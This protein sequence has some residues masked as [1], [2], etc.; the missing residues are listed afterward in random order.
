MRSNGENR[1]PEIITVCGIGGIACDSDYIGVLANLKVLQ[2]L[3]KEGCQVEGNERYF[4]QLL[5]MDR[6][7]IKKIKKYAGRMS[8]DIYFNLIKNLLCVNGK[9]VIKLKR[10]FEKNKTA[11]KL[12]SGLEAWEL[13]SVK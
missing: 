11:F 13:T 9:G 12:L 3:K 7:Q 1:V 4:L 10:I 2:K 6:G 5:I 8:H